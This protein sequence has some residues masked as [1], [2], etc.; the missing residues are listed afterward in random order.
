MALTPLS[1][2][3]ERNPGIDLDLSW[4]QEARVNLAAL[5][6]RAETHATRRSVKVG[7]LLLASRPALQARHHHSSPP[8]DDVCL[9]RWNG[10][11]A[12]CCELLPAST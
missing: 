5:K 12:G 1:M 9:G 4:V 11:L 10:K 7:G 8:F 2:V 6:L 3:H